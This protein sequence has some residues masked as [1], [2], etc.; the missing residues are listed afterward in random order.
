MA[1]A[2][3]LTLPL[4]LQTYIYELVLVKDEPIR[5]LIVETPDDKKRIPPSLSLLST[6]HSIRAIS[7]PIYYGDNTFVIAGMDDD[8]QSEAEKALAFLNATTLR[9]CRR[10]IVEL[11]FSDFNCHATGC[12]DLLEED[13]ITYF[14]SIEMDF[15]ARKVECDLSLPCCGREQTWYTPLI[16]YLQSIVE[17]K[18]R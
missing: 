13:D 3:L 7:R 2:T 10:V 6:C 12:P 16:D 15:K 1:K 4:E 9:L 5:P 17:D 14:T 18:A 8:V 11:T